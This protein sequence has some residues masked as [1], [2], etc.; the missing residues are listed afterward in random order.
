L[1]MCYK[2]RTRSGARPRNYTPIRALTLYHI[3]LQ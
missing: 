2:R 1:Q 3:A